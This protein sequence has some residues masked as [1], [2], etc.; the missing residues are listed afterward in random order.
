M[1]GEPL[2]VFGCP[3]EIDDRVPRD[4][5]AMT[6][7]YDNKIVAP[8][9]DVLLHVSSADLADIPELKRSPYCCL[10]KRS[11]A[12]SRAWRQA[13]RLRKRGIPAFVD[14]HSKSGRIDLRI[15][16]WRCMGLDTA[17][18]ERWDPPLP[19]L[20]IVDGYGRSRLMGMFARW[21]LEAE[22]AKVLGVPERALRG[23]W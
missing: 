2:E 22:I 14:L 3:V 4:V 21:L 16:K 19:D 6:M 20:I 12:H 9:P 13:K 7:R 18:G 1:N 15:D 17:T 11:V 23:E 8:F 5:I 10:G